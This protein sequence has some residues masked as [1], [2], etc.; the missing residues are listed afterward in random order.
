MNCQCVVSGRAE[1]PTLLAVAVCNKSHCR[2]EANVAFCSQSDLRLDLFRMD[3]KCA[4][5]E[6]G[7]F[8]NVCF[9]LHADLF[10]I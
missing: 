10:M 7:I 6:S 4:G 5:F 8:T 3:I 1:V 9:M 2:N